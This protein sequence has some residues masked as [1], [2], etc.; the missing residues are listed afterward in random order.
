MKA[1]AMKVAAVLMAAGM[2][3]TPFTS[4]AAEPGTG[5]ADNGVQNPG[6]NTYFS[7]DSSWS[8]GSGKIYITYDTKGGVWYEPGSSIES[9][10]DNI[11]HPNGTYVV[12]IP[13]AITYENM[14]IGAVNTNDNYEVHVRGAINPAKYVKVTAQADN[15]SILTNG[16]GQSIKITLSQQKTDFSADDCF[17]GSAS[18]LTPE[19]VTGGG[20][21]SLLNPDG[22]LKGSQSMDNIKLSGVVT[23]AGTFS[24][25]VTYTA[26]ELDAA[27]ASESST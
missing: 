25:T 22:S 21:A 6:G 14:S 27:D 13:T 16:K 11:Q 9:S 5:S 2:A 7:G 26:Q 1:R 20:L 15:G 8:S 23:T 4:F 19:E 12:T 3:M 18:E 24:G 10:D 17:G